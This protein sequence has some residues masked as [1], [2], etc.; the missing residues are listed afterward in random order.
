MMW[1]REN[2]GS[3]WQPT[4]RVVVFL[5]IGEACFLQPGSRNVETYVMLVFLSVIAHA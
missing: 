2:R 1:V 3:R 4:Q 5:G